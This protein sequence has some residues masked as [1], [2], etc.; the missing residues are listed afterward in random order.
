MPHDPESAQ[1]HAFAH[2]IAHHHDANSD[3]HFGDAIDLAT[4]L[5]LH[6]FEEARHAP[7]IF[8]LP[9]IQKSCGSRSLAIAALGI[10][11]CWPRQ[12]PGV[13]TEWT[14]APSGNT[15]AKLVTFPQEL[16]ANYLKEKSDHAHAQIEEPGLQ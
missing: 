5:E 14:N 13:Q 12:G 7:A 15:P 9:A 10:C 3:W 2:L 16:W 8:D 1:N 4:A 11:G 6:V